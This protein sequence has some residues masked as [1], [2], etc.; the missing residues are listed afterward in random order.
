M[1]VRSACLPGL[2]ASQHHA[3][4]LSNTALTPHLL[5][6]APCTLTPHLCLCPGP[7]SHAA[8]LR[9]CPGPWPMLPHCVCGLCPC[10]DEYLDPLT[11]PSPVACVR[12]P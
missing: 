12:A 8:S 1:V 5:D 3:A 7:W 4:G 10:Q 2:R 9:L 6:L 11:P